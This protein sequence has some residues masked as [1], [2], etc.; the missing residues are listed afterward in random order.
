MPSLTEHCMFTEKRY[1]VTG[2][3]IH[4][5]MD[6]PVIVQGPTH[7]KFRHDPN[8][9]I[10]QY[11][12]EEYGSTLAR[13]IMLDHILEDSKTPDGHSLIVDVPQIKLF[14]KIQELEQENQALKKIVENKEGDIVNPRY[15]C[16]PEQNES[17]DDWINRLSNIETNNNYD[18]QQ[19]NGAAPLSDMLPELNESYESWSQRF[20]EWYK[21]TRLNNTKTNH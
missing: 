10:P 4:K 1:G 5:W 7:R 17:F 9:K 18:I 2:E 20:D 15:E 11:L 12:I 19:E 3:S 6:E 14:E 8:Q 21:H 16:L 13:D